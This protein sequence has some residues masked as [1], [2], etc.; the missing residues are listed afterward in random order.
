MRVLYSILGVLALLSIVPQARIL[1]FKHTC[2]SDV[3][4]CRMKCNADE[5]AIRYCSDWTICCKRKKYQ[6]TKKKYWQEDLGGSD[7]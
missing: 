7:S 2:S 3:Y 6:P 5:H 1:F 4:S